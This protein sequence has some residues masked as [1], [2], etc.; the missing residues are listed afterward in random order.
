MENLH[1]YIKSLTIKT[2]GNISGKTAVKK[3]AKIS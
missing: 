3:Q 1:F 2:K